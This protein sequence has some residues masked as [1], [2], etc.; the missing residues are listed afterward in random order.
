MPSGTTASAG[1]TTEVMV[2]GTPRRA[3]TERA[4]ADSTT[5]WSAAARAAQPSRAITLPSVRSSPGTEGSW[6]AWPTTGTP[7][8]ARAVT[9][10]A[11]ARQPTAWTVPS[12]ATRASSLDSSPADGDAV[13]AL[14]VGAGRDVE[15]DVRDGVGGAGRGLR[16]QREVERAHEA[17]VDALAPEPVPQGARVYEGVGRDAASTQVRRPDEDGQCHL[18]Q[19]LLPLEGTP[20]A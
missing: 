5:T 13:G 3:A 12:V 11:V 15:H 16:E 2:S 1:P 6:S 7:V 9:A 18:F 17:H 20:S 14:L 19:P 8:M 10:T 4:Q